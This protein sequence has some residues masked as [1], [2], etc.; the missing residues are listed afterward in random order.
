MINKRELIATEAQTIILYLGDAK[1]IANY[2]AKLCKEEGLEDDA[3]KFEITR[4]ILDDLIKNITP[5]KLDSK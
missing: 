4:D 3:K 1:E 2:T 5:A